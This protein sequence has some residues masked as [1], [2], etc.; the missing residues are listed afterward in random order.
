LKQIYSSITAL[1]FTLRYAMRSLRRN[2]SRT[3]L[4]LGMIAVG[5]FVATLSLALGMG[6]YTTI[7]ALVTQSGLGDYQILPEAQLK[8]SDFYESFPFSKDTPLW[9]ELERM[10]LTFTPRAETAGI[11]ASEL[12]SVGVQVIGIDPQ[13]EPLVSRLP[14][15]IV[16]GGFFRPHPMT[17]P[18][19]VLIGTAL[20]AK[21]RA[22]PGSE[23]SFIGQ[24]GDGSIVA[25]NVS[26][27]GI[28]DLGNPMQNFRT[29]FFDLQ[30]LQGISALGNQVHRILIRDNP[31]RPLVPEALAR[32]ISAM[33]SPHSEES[34]NFAYSDSKLIVADW[35]QLVP[36]LSESIEA[37]RKG[38]IIF[39]F[40][41][42]LVVL[43]GVS[44]TMMMSAF[45]RSREVG[46]LKALGTHV[47]R[48]FLMFQLEAAIIVTT[49]S[50]LGALSSWFIAPHISIPLGEKGMSWAGVVLRSMQ[51]R[52]T[53]ND[54]ASSVASIFICGMIASVPPVIRVLRKTITEA[55]QEDA[56]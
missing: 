24:A 16:E 17:G 2:P 21:L 52:A 49:G 40:F 1:G 37:D 6:A 31:R 35:R 29:V 48:I 22:N 38:N 3:Y 51:A 20:A 56:P 25:E 15:T 10:G 8:R 23:L 36:E 39:L 9:A 11:L 18:P 26:V 30:I 45:E 32:D 44:N 19:Q 33:W 14:E 4:T 12:Q 54:Y 7:I 43:I 46:L 55:L 47:H 5:T 50:L 42:L 27:R 13:H 34:S 28:F 41:V 53:W